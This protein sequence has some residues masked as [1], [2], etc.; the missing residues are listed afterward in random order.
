METVLSAIVVIFIVL[1]AALTLSHA[2]ISGQDQ[3]QATLQGMEE[4]LAEQGRTSVAMVQARTTNDGSVVRATYENN[5]TVK[6]SDFQEWDL[7]VQYYDTSDPSN[8][9]VEYLPYVASSPTA[10][11][12]T[13]YG[14]Y[15]N[16][17]QG[18]AEHFEPGILNP[19]EQIMVEA[20]LS[21]PVAAGTQVQLTLAVKNGVTVPQVFVRN[22][23]PVLA[24]NNA[25]LIPAGGTALINEVQLLTT[26]VDNEI[27][28]LVYTVTTPPA[29]GA[30]TLGSTFT[31]DDID[32]D[33]LEYSH[34]G[35]GADSFEFMVSDGLDVIGTYTM[36]INVSEPPQL[37]VN[38][39]MVMASNT[40]SL[41]GDLMLMASDPDNAADEITFTVTSLP[42]QGSL[43]MTTFT[44]DDINNA[45]L[46]YAHVGAGPD[47]FQFTISDGLTKI[48]PF[49]F[50]I[51]VS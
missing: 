23:P 45:L 37:I 11:Q 6:I 29:E 1:F 8:Y 27:D 38:T 3:Y 22:F 25:M 4:R 7:I 47:S 24:I 10:D 48:G 17:K 42:T 14:I 12:W 5:G 15:A 32:H 9:H 43:S 50:G 31:Q 40:S 21:Q 26:D 19:G 13:I 28:E 35:S 44:Q 2:F 51:T 46:Q 41:I 34:T 39:G 16:A 36:T 49:T 20:P 18:L 30:L 33:R